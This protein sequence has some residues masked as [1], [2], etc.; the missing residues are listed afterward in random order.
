MTCPVCG[1]KTKV[2]D[3][4]TTGD[5]NFRRRKCVECNYICLTKEID[6]NE[7]E[8]VGRWKTTDQ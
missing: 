3:V 7:K 8:Y 1:G 5:C 2:V 6:C 4:T